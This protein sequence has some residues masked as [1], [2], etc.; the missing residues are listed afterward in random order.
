MVFLA[1][2]PKSGPFHV[3]K[4]GHVFYVRNLMLFQNYIL[5]VLAFALGSSS[6]FIFFELIKLYQVNYCCYILIISFSMFL[7]IY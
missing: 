1:R 6:V 3:F 5:N 4:R 7:Q 2:G